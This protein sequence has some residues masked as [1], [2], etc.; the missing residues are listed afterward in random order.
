MPNEL[1]SFSLGAPK[2]R[3][4]CVWSTAYGM[5]VNGGKKIT[6]SLIDRVQDRDGKTIWRADS[7]D[8][9]GCQSAGWTPQ[10]TPPDL[11]DTREQVED[12]R[13]RPIRW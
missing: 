4:R 7:R 5:I 1:L 13:T 8:C 6:P 2:K 10:L 9:T 12:P 3:P 11:P